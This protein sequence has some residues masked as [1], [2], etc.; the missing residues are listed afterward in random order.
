MRL[1]YRLSL[2]CVC[3]IGLIILLTSIHYISPNALSPSRAMKQV[4]PPDAIFGVETNT[5]RIANPIINQRTQQLGVSWIRLN[6]VSWQSVQPTEERVYHWDALETFEEELLAARAANLTPIVVVDDN[7]AWA[8]IPYQDPTTGATKHARCGAVQAERFHDFAAFMQALV[9]RYSKAPYSVRYWEIGNEIDIDPRLL[10]EFLHGFFGCWGNIEDPYYG[11]EHYGHML[12]VVTPAI[13]AIDPNAQIVIGGLALDTPHT[14]DT[15]KGY[16]ERF[17][18]GILK[19]GAGDSFDIVGFHVYPWYRGNLAETK[20]QAQNTDKQ[21]YSD[22]DRY[23]EKWVLWGGTTLG[24]VRYLREMMLQYGI[25]KPLFLNETALVKDSPHTQHFYEAQADHL[26]RQ[27]VRAMFADV[28]TFIWYTLHESGWLS[29]GLLDRDYQP[30]PPYTAYA[31]LIKQAHKSD[32]HPLAITSY[33]NT[34]EAYRLKQKTAY[35]DIVWST[36]AI[37]KYISLSP[38]L[39]QTAY[40]LN[41]TPAPI[42]QD[43]TGTHML[44]GDSPVYLF[45]RYPNPIV[46]SVFPKEQIAQIP[47]TIFITGSNFLPDAQVWLGDHLLEDSTVVDSQQIQAVVPANLTPN[48]YPLIIKHPD[49][50]QHTLPLAYT[51][52]AE[53]PHIR[54]IWYPYGREDKAEIFHIYGQSF[55]DGCT[56][57]IG[58]L[59]VHAQRVRGDQ[60]LVTVPTRVFAAGTYTVT[61]TNPN[62]KQALL[63]NGYHIASGNETRLY[64]HEREFWT[65]PATPRV[66]QSTQVGVNLHYPNRNQQISGVAVDFYQGNPQQDGIM[67]GSSI[68]GNIDPGTM[69]RTPPIIWKPDRTGST[70]LYAIVNYTQAMSQSIQHTLIVS[71]TIQVHP[72][73]QDR[74]APHITKFGINSGNEVTY[75]R[76]FFLDVGITDSESRNGQTNILLIEYVYSQGAGA[77]IPVQQSGWF[78][79]TGTTRYSWSLVPLP[80]VHY[81][82]VWAADTD[83]NVCADPAKG[84]INYLPMRDE[85]EQGHG[86]VYR[87]PLQTDERLSIRL[88]SLRG[89]PDIY[90]WKKGSPTPIAVSDLWYETDLID[91]VARQDSLYQ[92]EVYDCQGCVDG[93]SYYDPMAYRMLVEVTQASSGNEGQNRYVS[94][95]Q[96]MRR[97]TPL[98]PLDH[99]SYQ[100][101]ALP[102]APIPFHS[103]IYLPLLEHESVNDLR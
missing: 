29:A 6:T 34:I 82:Q 4:P 57:S 35:F 59:P 77:W 50:K 91:M 42:E 23:D 19:A 99:E 43:E 40:T 44:I 56:V 10:T 90:V 70:T 51:I 1:F 17:F 64:S 16:P 45:Y 66:H 32:M 39:F 65:E 102:P 74:I 48:T 21:L 14:T 47:S 60:L 15:T 38:T 52:L 7:P 69:V 85:V 81:M 75:D 83:G 41:G 100:W 86:R 5:G 8:T 54:E 55:H 72:A 58:S 76:N 92:V 2:I 46:T 89:D 12:Q 53:T 36:D 27:V 9:A 84:M 88:D 103:E 94:A 67:I 33:G 96:K 20:N 87:Y 101:W 63:A 80:G 13:K 97:N 3:A 31:Y 37:S 71:R 25:D 18:E 78:V 28:K 98:I 79:H 95:N 73:S 93:V 11:G 61:V 22:P 49:G 26:V 30:R 68:V 62:G 24:K